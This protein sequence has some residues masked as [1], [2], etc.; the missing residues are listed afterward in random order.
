MNAV[1]HEVDVLLNDV[2]SDASG[3]MGGPPPFLDLA[4]SEGA[5]GRWIADATPLA[6][7]AGELCRKGMGWV[8]MAIR[9]GSVSWDLSKIGDQFRLPR[10]LAGWEKTA[11]AEA[12]RI[13]ARDAKFRPVDAEAVAAVQ[14]DL[15]DA[16]A[17]N[18]WAF[19]SKVEIAQGFA[20]AASLT[21]GQHRFA[22]ALL[23]DARCVVA[24]VDHRLADPA[25]QEALAQAEGREADLLEA[26]R[27]ISALDQDRARDANGIGWDAVSSP[28]GH[29]L[30]GRDRLTPI[31]AGHALQLVYRHRR[32][33][34]S[35]LQDR[36]GL[37]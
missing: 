34:P 8:G 6:R 14:V 19:G 33:L 2:Q 4:W 10:L 17:V 27:A 23:Q 11:R 9:D 37:A 12:A 7:I 26:C 35:D 15:R 1:H 25:G 13:E 32:Q 29:R 5:D 3:T 30:S 31:E 36:L 24:A 21:P 18:R 16:L 20:G 28:A 22:R